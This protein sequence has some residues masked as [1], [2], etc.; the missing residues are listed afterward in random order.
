MRKEKGRS[1]D[2]PSLFRWNLFPAAGLQF[3]GLVALD[4]L[5]QYFHSLLQLRVTSGEEIFRQVVHID[6]GRNAIVLQVVALHVVEAGS[7]R[8]DVG[9]VEQA[10]RSRADHGA[11][12]RSADYFAE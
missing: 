5:F 1:D 4:L 7:R 11:V 8:A 10:K 9:A 12:G 2:R 3:A 6:V